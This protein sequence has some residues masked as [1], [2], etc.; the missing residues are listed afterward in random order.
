MTIYFVHI[1]FII[2]YIMQASVPNFWI[3][4][5]CRNVQQQKFRTDTQLVILSY[6]TESCTH[7]E[8]R[9]LQ[10][11]I[12]SPQNI[13]FY[14]T[15]IIQQ[16]SPSSIAYVSIFFYPC[17]TGM[18]QRSVLSI[19]IQFVLVLLCTT[20]DKLPQQKVMILISVQI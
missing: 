3:N 1:S 13:T 10:E 18:W 4:L 5:F 16:S 11:N 20:K 14:K 9:H 17:E 19:N 15:A 6:S 8:Q 7:R 12:I 2:L